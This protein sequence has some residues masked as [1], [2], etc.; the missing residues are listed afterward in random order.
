MPWEYAGKEVRV[1]DYGRDVEVRY[2]S[3]RIAAHSQAVR[4]HQIITQSEHH[5]GIPLETDNRVAKL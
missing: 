2:G 5:E 1:R 4:R 3:E